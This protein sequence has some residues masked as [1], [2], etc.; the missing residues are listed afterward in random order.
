MK[1]SDTCWR[2]IARVCEVEYSDFIGKRFLFQY[3]QIATQ[4][5][6]PS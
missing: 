4:S 2:L 6:N 5:Y 3:L 1:T